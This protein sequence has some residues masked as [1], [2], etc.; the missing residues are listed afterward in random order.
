MAGIDEEGLMKTEIL[1]KTFAVSDVVPA[2]EPLPDQ[3]YH[4]AVSDFLGGPIESC[5]RYHG[6]LI[7]GV[8]SHPLIGALHAAF[9]SHRP[10]GLSPDIIWL[11]IC[12]GLAHHVNINAEVLRHRLVKHEGKATLVVRR[13]DFVKGS[14][15]NPWPGVF[16]DFSEAIRAHIG[17][18]HDLI[19]ADFSTTGPVERAASE[20]SILG[21][22]QAF[23]DYEVRTLCGIPS[24]TLEGTAEDWRKIAARVREFRRF[25]L[26]WWVKPLLPVLDQFVAAA[27]GQVDRR[28]WDS[29]YKW[30]GSKGSGSPHVSGWVFKLFPYL[31]NPEV[32]FARLYGG[33]E[34]TAPSLRRNPWLSAPPARD[35]PGRDDF[36]SLPAKAPFLWKFPH[37]GTE[38]GME[39]VGGLLGI[40]Q[41]QETL[42]LRPEIGWAIREAS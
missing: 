16:A 34:S 2:T 36:P 26:D 40:S 19:V 14:P 10:V 3:P 22:M 12:Q 42:C 35:G 20:I 11:T 33:R 21:A 15:E 31:D 18:A 30:Q 24:I 37:L 4:Q 29:I 5:S 38:Y 8:R 13:D 9:S 7:A 28:F 25:D 41:D 17:E 32:K 27:E 1:A 39:F 6:R 23:F